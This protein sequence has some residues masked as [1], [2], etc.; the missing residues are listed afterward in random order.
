MGKL[1][2]IVQ[3]VIRRIKNHHPKRSKKKKAASK[4]PS[5]PK[6]KEPRVE[7]EELTWN[8]NSIRSEFITKSKAWWKNISGSQKLVGR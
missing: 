2:V 7:Q 3:M 4:K 1:I 5:E 8:Y 6:N